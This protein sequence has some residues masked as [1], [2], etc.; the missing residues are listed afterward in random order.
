M[1]KLEKFEPSA[2]IDVIK[3][4][5]NHDDKLRVI[6]VCK[7][8]NR[9]GVVEEDAIKLTNFAQVSIKIQE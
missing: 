2:I 7:K 5:T 6:S 3:I 9:F 4:H 1:E 8:N